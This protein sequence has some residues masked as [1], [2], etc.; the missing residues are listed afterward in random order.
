VLPFLSYAILVSWAV[1]LDVKY[2][3]MIQMPGMSVI[4][5]W[6]IIQFAVIRIDLYRVG[7]AILILLGMYAG[8]VI[9]FTVAV[10]V[11]GDGFNASWVPPSEKHSWVSAFTFNA[12]VSLMFFAI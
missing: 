3:N 5:A 7:S 4:L 10:S 2:M 9:C 6:G 11:Q 12:P 8:W 1:A